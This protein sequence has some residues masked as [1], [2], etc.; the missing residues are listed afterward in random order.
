[1]LVTVPDEL[2]VPETTNDRTA[3]DLVCTD[4]AGETVL[5]SR[6]G[7]P[8]LRDGDPPAPHAHQQAS[9]AELKSIARCKLAGTEPELSDDMGLAR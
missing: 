5:R 2:N 9:P 8:F 4:D 6:Q 3:V 1:M 7:W